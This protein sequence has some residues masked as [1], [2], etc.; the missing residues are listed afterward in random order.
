[1]FEGRFWEFALLIV[2][3]LI[4]FGP[5]RLPR[6]A[7]TI[8]LWVGRARTVLRNLGEQIEREAELE[9][10]RRTATT[11]QRAVRDPLS[12][13]RGPEPSPSDTAKHEPPGR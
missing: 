8:G 3:A 2:I 9:E 1:M 13:A 11:A 4:V 10:L 12:A 5:E 7:R 6:V